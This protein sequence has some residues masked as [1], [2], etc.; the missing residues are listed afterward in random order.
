[1]N[2]TQLRAFHRVAQAGSYSLAARSHRISQPTLSAQVKE[3]EATYGVALFDRRG[4][5]VQ[6]TPDSRFTP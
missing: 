1:M 4:R 5:G 2:L 3:L 6:L